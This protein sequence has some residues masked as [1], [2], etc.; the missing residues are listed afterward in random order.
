MHADCDIGDRKC[1]ADEKRFRAHF[2]FEIVEHG[3]EFV[4]QGRGDHGLIGLTAQQSFHDALEI[5]PGAD[6]LGERGIRIF[7][8]P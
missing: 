5:N 2:H 7:L 6:R 1:V 3:R 8:E 4:L